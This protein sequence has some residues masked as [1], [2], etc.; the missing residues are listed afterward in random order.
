MPRI[1]TRLL[2]SSQGLGVVQQNPH[3][4]GARRG[5]G[6]E[7]LT[8]L[9]CELCRE[10]TRRGRVETEPIHGRHV[11]PADDRV[12]SRLQVHHVVAVN[13]RAVHDQRRS[14]V[15]DLNRLTYQHWNLPVRDETDS[16]DPTGLPRRV[17]VDL[18]ES[19]PIPPRLFSQYRLGIRVPV[20]V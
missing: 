8:L 16:N 9:E 5:D 20:R 11:V 15:I 17:A 18:H 13:L 19:L 7:L 12:E 4:V 1:I 10:G 2:T 14:G 6:V 3:V